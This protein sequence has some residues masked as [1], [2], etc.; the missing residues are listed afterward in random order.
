VI[1]RLTV[2]AI[3]CTCL[4]V[5]PMR[6]Q[7]VA[8]PPRAR[9]VVQAPTTIVVPVG[10][11]I[12]LPVKNG[13]IRTITVGNPDI[14]SVEPFGNAPGDKYLL[15]GRKEGSTNLQMFDENDN[16]IYDAIVYISNSVPTPAPRPPGYVFIYDDRRAVYGYTSFYCRENGCQWAKAPVGLNEEIVQKLPTLIEPNGTAI[17]GIR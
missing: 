15:N 10:M 5:T 8:A 16:R 14:L 7:E 6:A 11:S 17:T 3:A 13:H 4:A 9:E 12:V 1:R 2:F